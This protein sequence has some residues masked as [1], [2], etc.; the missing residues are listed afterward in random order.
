MTVRAP[1]GLSGHLRFVRGHGVTGVLGGHRVH[2]PARAVRGAVEP[3]L[4]H[5]IG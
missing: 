4:V 5:A 2:L 1:E 3:A